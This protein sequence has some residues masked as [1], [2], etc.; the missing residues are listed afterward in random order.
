VIDSRAA[1]GNAKVE[2][3]DF[4][5]LSQSFM[6]IL[7]A[8]D[9]DGDNVVS[10]ELDWLSRRKVPTRRAFLTEM[11]CLRFPDKYPVLNQPVQDYL[12]AVGYKA[13]R[14]ASEG[15]RFL[16]LAK[17]LRSSLLQNPEHPAKNLAEPDTIIWLAYGKKNDSGLH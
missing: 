8:T 15:A 16:H 6:R 10:S 11:L 7:D 13:T 4:H 2:T 14:G 1:A 12:K 9:A 17:A 3:P 5:T